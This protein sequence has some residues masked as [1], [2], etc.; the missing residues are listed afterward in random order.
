MTFSDIVYLPIRDLLQLICEKADELAEEAEDEILDT[1]SFEINGFIRDIQ[2]SINGEN[3][4]FLH[5]I[6]HFL[7]GSDIAAATIRVIPDQFAALIALIRLGILLEEDPQLDFEAEPSADADDFILVADFPDQLPLTSFGYENP[8]SPKDSVGFIDFSNANWHLTVESSGLTHTLLAVFF[9]HIAKLR[10]GFSP[11]PLILV[12]KEASP[13]A[14]KSALRLQAVAH[15]KTIHVPATSTISPSLAAVNAITALQ[16]IQQFDE[17][18]LILSEYNS[19]TDVIGKFLSLYHVIESFMYKVPLVELSNANNGNMF[20]IRDFKRIYR[21]VDI[22]EFAA[23]MQ[24]MERFWRS[25]VQS[26]Q[27]LAHVTSALQS[28]DRDRTI[29]ARRADDFLAKLGLHTTNGLNQLSNGINVKTFSKLVYALRNAIVHN[30]E[31]EF[32]VSHHNLHVEGRRLIEEVVM[33][34][35]EALLYTL[36][37]D[38]TSSVWYRGSV[39]RLYAT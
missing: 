37:S 8:L 38:H 18:I 33:R 19:R 7:S 31:T 30:G 21:H 28:L 10:V 34:P 11:A 3:R 16:P 22:N 14:A 36:I 20:S 13:S 27:F 25:S 35:L 26:R 4:R 17:L 1:L 12:R 15:G 39:L 29:D 24:L 2:L 6:S 5:A 23:L 32:H 9:H